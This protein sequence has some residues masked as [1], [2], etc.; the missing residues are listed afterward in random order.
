MTGRLRI[1]GGSVMMLVTVMAGADGA[2]AQHAGHG[3][4]GGHGDGHRRAQACA[5]EFEA[6]VGAGLGFGMAFAA[7]QNGYPG[8]IHLLELKDRLALTPEQET[9]ARGLLD[10]MFARSRPAGARLLSAE[11]ALRAIFAGGAADEAAVRAA[12][13]EVEQARAELRLVHLLS[14][15]QTRDLLTPEQR[16][17]YHE[18]RWRDR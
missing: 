8:P 7:D 18:A 5:A 16:R 9:R 2:A 4:A 13:A 10:A 15:L 3:G 11:A 6:V 17:A 1:L 14:H 12:M